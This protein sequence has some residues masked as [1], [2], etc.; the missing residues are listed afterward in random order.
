[1]NDPQHLG[2]GELGQRVQAMS[3]PAPDQRLR[4]YEGVPAATGS[5]SN[6]R[7][8]SSSGPVPGPSLEAYE[9][10]RVSQI[11]PPSP[12]PYQP[13]S[14]IPAPP[15]AA[16]PRSHSE[17]VYDRAPAWET[18]SSR[19]PAASPSQSR[20]IPPMP[21]QTA[22]SPSQAPSSDTS[23]APRS[24]LH[25]AFDAIRS[26]LPLV[27]KILPIIDGNFATAV[28]ALMASQPHPTPPPAQVHIDLEPIEHGLA[29]IRDSNR[30]LRGQ[31][32]EQVTNLKRVE[33]QL[34]RVREATDRNTLEQ[35]EL[36]EDLRSASGRIS[37]FAMLGAVL[38]AISLGLNI[39]LII[40]LQHI[41]R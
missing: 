13:A 15:P 8:S 20:S 17:A 14:T 3:D 35:Q 1:M 28:S 34:E 33:D 30:E 18:I 26:T 27:Q 40:Q 6:G 29:E 41:L 7:P 21:S 5:S 36:V 11:P 4:P 22:S 2:L 12:Q 10:Y 23:N 38:L 9:D 32:L 25:R 19:P 31:V 24:G 39:Y 16:T 37:T